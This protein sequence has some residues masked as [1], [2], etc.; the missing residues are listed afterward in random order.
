MF[1]DDT[2]LL[3]SQQNINTLFRIFNEELKKIAD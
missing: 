3:L 2:N 1:A